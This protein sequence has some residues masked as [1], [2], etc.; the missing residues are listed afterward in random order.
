MLVSDAVLPFSLGPHRGRGS[1]FPWYEGSGSGNLRS[2]SPHRRSPFP[3]PGGRVPA[4]PRSDM[5]HNARRHHRRPTPSVRRR[6]SSRC[7]RAAHLA[8]SGS[9]SAPARPR[10]CTPF[11]HWE[12]MV[13]RSTCATMMYVQCFRPRLLSSPPADFHA[14]LVHP[15]ALIAPRCGPQTRQ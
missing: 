7:S 12:I 9:W 3:S 8:R 5:P 14:I 11:L 6:T 1:R 10:P 13:D 4:T 15:L 2:A